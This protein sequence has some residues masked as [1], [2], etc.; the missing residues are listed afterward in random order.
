M[1]WL[2]WTGG[3]V[4]M[5]GLLWVF[6]GADLVAGGSE[7]DLAAGGLLFIVGVLMMGLDMKAGVGDG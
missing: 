4:S 7:S 3:V 5:A 6:Q 2:F 1:R